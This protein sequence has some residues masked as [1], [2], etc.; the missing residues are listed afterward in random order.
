MRRSKSCVYPV[1]GLRGRLKDVLS[2]VR[3]WCLLG[4]DAHQ[5]SLPFQHLAVP[6]PGI[7]VECRLGGLL[8]VA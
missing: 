3:E 6:R 4:R 1:A 2:W 7:G 5:N 8:G